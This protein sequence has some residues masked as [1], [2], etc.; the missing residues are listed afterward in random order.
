MVGS[1]NVLNIHWT[2]KKTSI[3][4]Q[5][6]IFWISGMLL[7]EPSQ[8]YNTQP[9]LATPLYYWVVISTNLVQYSDKVCALMSVASL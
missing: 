9:N 4:Y 7:D 6:Q 8:T 2:I 3:D 1:Y 5:E